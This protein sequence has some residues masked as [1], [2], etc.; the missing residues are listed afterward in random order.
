M[1]HKVRHALNTLSENIQQ[2]TPQIEEK[3]R[4][5]GVD[6]DPALVYTAAKYFEALNRLASE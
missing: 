3:L 1:S 4:L 5:A 2:N 6:P